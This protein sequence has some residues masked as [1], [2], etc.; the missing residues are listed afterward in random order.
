MWLRPT[1][2]VLRDKSAPIWQTGHED[3]PMTEC[4]FKWVKDDDVMVGVNTPGKAWRYDTVP[5]ELIFNYTGLSSDG[6]T[7]YDE[8]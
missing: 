3:K 8:F 5:G 1:P 7:R 2:T 4:I 6:K